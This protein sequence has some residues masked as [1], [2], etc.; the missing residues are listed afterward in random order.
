[1]IYITGDT[2]IPVDV[3]KLSSK[4]FPQQKSL[5][6][7]DYLIICGDFGGVWCGDSEERYWMKWLD[8]KNFT[9]L[10][11]DGNHE[12]F[13]MLSLL[14]E[15]DFCGGRV[16]RA[17]KKIFHLMRGY[18]FEIDGK[19]VFTFGGASSH[20]REYRTEGKNWWRG[21][22]PTAD[23]TDRALHNLSKSDWQVD[24][25]ITHCAPTSVQ[26]K[27]DSS[28]E[29]NVLTDFLENVNVRLDFKSWYFGHYHTDAVIDK[30]YTAIYNNVVRF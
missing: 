28:Y 1:M 30:K 23:E 14:P 24:T 17:G 10:F 11:V 12:N 29:E 2:H 20:D 19:R 13:D 21:E 3:N 18:V 6:E 15:E 9:T 26:R 8:E 7:K 4:R 25:V 27:L 16:H 5:T 22:L